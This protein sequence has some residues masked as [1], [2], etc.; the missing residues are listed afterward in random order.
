M[1]VARLP[2]AVFEYALSSRNLRRMFAGC[3]S[4]DATLEHHL[5][6]GLQTLFTSPRIRAC[7]IAPETNEVIRS[8]APLRISFCGG[9]TDVAPYPALYGG[10]VLS[11][12]IERYAYVSV[13]NH[14]AR[15]IRVHSEDT[16]HEIVFDPDRPEASSGKLDLAQAIFQRFGAS[17]MDCFMHSDAPP[18][19]GL[20]SSSAM[21]VAFITALALKTGTHLTTDDV[22]E[23]AYAVEREDLGIVGGMQDQYASAFGGFNF[24]EF[25]S[26]GVHVT[27]LRLSENAIA[28]LH[29][30][31]MLCDTGTT[32]LSSNIVADQTAGLIAHNADVVDGLAA[33]K[34]MTVTMMRRLLKGRLMEFG[35]LLDDAWQF[36]RR[37]S[38]HITSDAIDDLYD[39]AKRA[40]AIGGKILGAGGG[41]H[42]LLFVPFDRRNAVRERVERAGGKVVDFQFDRSGARAW[43]VTGDHWTGS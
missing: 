36:K 9:G 26:D 5:P 11:A 1:F 37:L 31:L 17:A 39:S 21:I 23:F 38:R 13:R 27:P 3:H 35:E 42:M 24:I 22:A 18:G 30:H 15:T 20:G 34:D 28:E 32:R 8:R 25:E 6:R 19:S 16:G 12:T 4:R 2:L 33:L 7:P 43:K 41:G 10:C 40:G 14:D 29:Y